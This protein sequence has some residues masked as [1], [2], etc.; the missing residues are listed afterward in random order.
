M[1]DL[2]KLY[3]E[4]Q[5]DSQKRSKVV[6]AVMVL[7][8]LA[9]PVGVFLTLRSQDTRSQAALIESRAP[10]TAITLVSRTPSVNNQSVFPVDVIIH[11]DQ[12]AANI[13]ATRLSFAADTLE[14][15][16]IAPSSPDLNDT[17]RVYP[18]TEWMDASFNNTEG[19]V[20]LISG[21]PQAG[22]KTSPTDPNEQLLATIY[23]KAKKG[24]T[25]TDILFQEGSMI[26]DVENSQNILAKAQSLTLKIND[27]IGDF[28]DGNF[29][30]QADQFKNTASSSATFKIDTPNGGEVLPYGSALNIRW[31]NT[32]EATQSA[33]NNQNGLR[34]SVS[35]AILLNETFLGFLDTVEDTG[36][37]IWNPSNTLPQVFIKP[38]NTFKIEVEKTNPQT[39]QKEKVVSS[40]PFN[41]TLNPSTSAQLL[42]PATLS[43]EKTDVNS[44][45]VRD[46]KDASF[47]LRNYF[48]PV[49]EKN[50]K[51]DF[52]N[53]RVINAIDL[54]YLK[55]SLNIK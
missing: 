44:D 14:V 50:L 8:L 4:G 5:P 34:T 38:E 33:K 9:M 22:L 29:K 26:L 40:G 42:S 32:A 48:A 3:V 39:N 21:V 54:W 30:V 43:S 55:Q 28:T 47:I 11:S 2:P 45:T 19:F 6:I 46:Y 53:D 49:T 52:N 24:G 35:V 17:K 51:A 37:Y 36:S 13:F 27:A 12:K 1:E 7:T 20:N 15:I 41:I 23:F 31:S 18:A 25:D 10:E 16:S